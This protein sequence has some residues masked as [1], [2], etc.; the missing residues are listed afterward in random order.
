MAGRLTRKS[1]QTTQD[2]IAEESYCIIPKDVLSSLIT[3][4][5]KYLDMVVELRQKTL[6]TF[7]NLT[8]KTT[9]LNK[10]ILDNSNII[11]EA[12][13]NLNRNTNTNVPRNNS[14]LGTLPITTEEFD[15]N[16]QVELQRRKRL[17]Y[18]IYQAQLLSSY[19]QSLL[20]HENPFVP[21]KFRA[22]VNTTTSE[23]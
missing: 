12:L 13:N 17:H 22:R 5:S 2:L 3:E 21:V 11:I 23:Y 15:A 10:S 6:D 14:S 1:Q 19:C 18:Q 9:E 20:N 16:V 4:N 8:Q 7:S